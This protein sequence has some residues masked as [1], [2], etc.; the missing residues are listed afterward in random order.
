MKYFTMCIMLLIISRVSA[1]VAVR[2]VTPAER[3]K[4][5][6]IAQQNKI[7]QRVALRLMENEPFQKEEDI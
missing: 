4:I 1:Q 3:Q 5:I 6:E 7:P 2:K